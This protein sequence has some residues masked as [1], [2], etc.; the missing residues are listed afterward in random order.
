MSTGVSFK[1]GDK[2]HICFDGRDEDAIVIGLGRDA[3]Y[4]QVLL[5]QHTGHSTW[6]EKNRS[7]VLALGKNPSG[8]CWNVLLKPEYIWKLKTNKRKVI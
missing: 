7:T 1:T 6:T 4:I 3:D 2:V 5:K 8:S